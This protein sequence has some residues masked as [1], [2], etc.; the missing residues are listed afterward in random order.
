MKTVPFWT[1]DF[2]R[3]QDLGGDP[4]PTDTTV[5][6]VGGGY[7]GLSA[8]RRLAQLGIQSAILERHT[9]G[10]GAS[11][12]NGGMTTTGL[13]LKPETLFKQYGRELGRALWDASLDAITA[14][15]SIVVA[16]AIDCDF[17]RHGSFA[18]AC[19][20][21]HF[22]AMCR[23]TEWMARELGYERENV[24]RSAMRSEIGS[25]AYYG[26]VVETLSGGLHPAKYVFGL[27][28]AAA[29]AGVTLCDRTEV[30]SITRSGDA[31]QLTT[32]SGVL[33]ADEVLIA[34]NG[35]T[36][37][38]PTA[39]RRRVVPIGSYSIVTEPLP[40]EL[41]QEISPRG[42]MF[43]D[44][45]WFLNYFRLT[46]DGRLLMGGRNNLT[47]DLDLVRSAQRLRETLVRI[48]P[49]LHDLPIT[50]SWGG[51]LGLT[52][53]TLP[54]IGRADGLHYAFGYSGHGVAMATL[55]GLHAAELLAGQRANSPFLEIPNPVYFFYRRRP[56]FLPL[57]ATGMRLL[58][59]LT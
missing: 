56:W 5:A 58:D 45:R 28:Q 40:P 21:A 57:V 35:Y 55:L 20:P 18:A 50:H 8:A 2:P 25:A 17:R 16:E 38:H 34:T 13:K 54:H 31:F 26:G 46:P 44:S 59:R 7:T 3:P 15:E 53:D 33:R 43:Y 52:F 9:I 48:F 11:S 1:D 30:R 42:R 49:Q 10:W 37:P 14:V 12:R 27:G 32:A 51:N 23:N 39:I 22:D 47:T 24:P 6:I 36:D 19:K 41:Q 4:L 29:R